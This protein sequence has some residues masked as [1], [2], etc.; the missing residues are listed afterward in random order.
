MARIAE[1]AR[2]IAWTSD[3]AWRRIDSALRSPLARRAE[4]AC[5]LGPGIVL[6]GGEVG[7]AEGALAGDPLLP[8]RVAA[9]AA[10]HGAAIERG[11]LERL[12]AGTPALGEPWP[13][14]A[15]SLLVALLLAGAR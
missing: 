6:R 14:E 10:A 11:S 15:R 5:T 13:P 1:A 12:A 2:S 8:L 4:R 3:D 7:L 9:A